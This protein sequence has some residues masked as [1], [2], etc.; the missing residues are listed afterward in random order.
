MHRLN[1]DNQSYA[2]DPGSPRDFDPM[3]EMES[4]N[5]FIA[6]LYFGRTEST[7]VFANFTLLSD[8][9]TDIQWTDSA[10][11]KS[12]RTPTDDSSFS[13]NLETSADENDEKSEPTR[14]HFGL[15]ENVKVELDKTLKKLSKIADRSSPE[16]QALIRTC[17]ESFESLIERSDTLFNTSLASI[18]FRTDCIKDGIKYRDLDDKVLD[19]KEQEKASLTGWMEK[20]TEAL[21]PYFRFEYHCANHCQAVDVIDGIQLRLEYGD[22]LKSIHQDEDAERVLIDAHNKAK[23]LTEPVVINGNK[24]TPIEVLNKVAPQFEKDLPLFVDPYKRLH[25]MDLRTHLDGEAKESIK[26]AMSLSLGKK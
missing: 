23:R 1:C 4:R 25:L 21:P 15:K 6:E 13:I 7:K 14:Q 12:A 20:T 26:R 22:F 24:R 19:R 3:V 17:K 11:E 10:V 8:F 9:P 2:D 18:E 16:A 5:S